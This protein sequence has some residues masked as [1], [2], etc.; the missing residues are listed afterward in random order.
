MISFGI[1][2]VSIVQLV[3]NVLSLH[4]NL[5]HVKTKAIIAIPGKL[6]AKNVFQS[7]AKNVSMLPRILKDLDKN[8][9]I[10]SLQ[11]LCK[12]TKNIPYKIHWR[13]NVFLKL[14]ISTA[15]DLNHSD[16]RNQNATKN[17]RK[18]LNAL[19][20]IGRIFLTKVK[21]FQYVFSIPNSLAP[22]ICHFAE[23]FG[24]DTIFIR[25]NVFK[26]V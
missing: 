11:I 17:V 18:T 5:F 8:I 15:I 23:H 10:D 7:L 4:Q 9:C 25:C 26:F 19:G 12:N 22:L 14:H 16:W 1:M 2:N 3:I 6:Y 24:T 13:A 21:D 20:F